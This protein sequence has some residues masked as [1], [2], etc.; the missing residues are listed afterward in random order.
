MQ[1]HAASGKEPVH[2]ADVLSPSPL[3]RSAQSG[4]YTINGEAGSTIAGRYLVEETIHQGTVTSIVAARHIG[5][6]TKVAIKFLCPEFRRDP[7]MI[8]RFSEQARSLAEIQS[9]HVLR[10]FDVGATLSLGTYVVLEHVEGR[11][12]AQI[13]QAH[14]PLPEAR[15]VEYALQVC[16]AL[17][18]AHASGIVHRKI[19]PDSLFLAR[20]RDFEAL[21]VL[22]FFEDE[23]AGRAHAKKLPS[24]LPASPYLAPEVIRCDASVDRRADIWSIG[25]TLYELIT[26]TTH[27][28][29]FSLETFP[30]ETSPLQTLPLERRTY[31][32]DPSLPA[33]Q[34]QQPVLSAAIRM[35]I[36]RCMQADPVHR[37]QSVDELAAALI[38]L[39]TLTE[40][41]RGNLT[42]VFSRQMLAAASAQA[43]AAQLPPQK[44][45][46]KSGRVPVDPLGSV[47]A[48]ATP[49]SLYGKLVASWRERV[50]ALP[51]AVFKRRH[52]IYVTIAI[53][54]G[55]AIALAL[56]SVRQNASLHHSDA[57]GASSVSVSTAY[58]STTARR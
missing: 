46:S 48:L 56:S 22:D 31:R 19:K 2:R 15:A 40:V 58:S 18:V 3:R 16:K 6:G 11:S 49:R 53:G 25:V 17:A 21:R 14:G 39:T 8:A 45:K 20:R 27:L 36:M 13:L 38:P 50:F 54:I 57:A 44:W 7:A 23:N 51:D 33:A 12:L 32:S 9:D 29:T 35:V 47:P 43:R 52:L 55:S 24:S 42:G 10:V 28:E 26:G 41:F 4:T 34:P 30:L 37:Y 5:L 1:D